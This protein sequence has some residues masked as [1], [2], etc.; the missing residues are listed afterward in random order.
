MKKLLPIFLTI[1]M[2][3][4]ISLLSPLSPL[5]RYSTTAYADELDDVNK[6]ISDLTDSLNKSVAAT[7][8][9]ESQLTSMKGQ[10]T[11][12]RSSIAYIDADVITKKKQIDNS[13]QHL[14]EK[15]QLFNKTIR[16]YYIKSYYNSPMVTLMSAGS[17]SEVTQNLAY[18]KAQTDQDKSIITNI[19]LAIGDL[20]TKRE[21]LK[22]EQAR[23]RHH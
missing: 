18:Q 17:A 15:Q 12:I 3:A 7:K 6:K 4:L 11:N 21:Q 22:I 23:L 10:L 20:E 2:F 14:A 16:D 8:P 5:I 1:L 9:L 19:A 13:Y